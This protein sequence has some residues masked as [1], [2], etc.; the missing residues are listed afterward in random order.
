MTYRIFGL[1][2]DSDIELPE[3]PRARPSSPDLLVRL[4]HVARVARDWTWID[5]RERP[6]GVP[7]LLI[8]RR[9]D[10][11]LLRFPRLADFTVPR[12]GRGAI[13]CRRRAG[14]PP[15]TLRHLL[16]D[17]VVPLALSARGHVLLH[18]SAVSCKG[19]ALILAGPS[20]SGKST[21]AFALT[22]QH[23]RLLSDDVVRLEVSGER[24]AEATP[25]YPGARLW[26]DVLDAFRAGIRTRRLVHYSSKLRVLPPRTAGARPLPVGAVYLLERASAIGVRPISSRAA[27]VD[28]LKQ[29][30]RLDVTDTATERRHFETLAA[31]AAAVPVRAVAY[32]RELAR[33]RDVVRAVVSCAS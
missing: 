1:L 17:Q 15:R 22:E 5:R 4:R 21:L 30:Y 25:A 7:W 11:W 10:G 33:L 12:S 6:D 19:R 16:L 13:T 20:G 24:L 8:G 27:L 28:L 18:A 9:E 2:L 14:V 31:M 29:T 26:P 32:P 23:A 3:L